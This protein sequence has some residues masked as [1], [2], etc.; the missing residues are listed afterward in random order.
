MLTSWIMISCFCCL[1]QLKVTSRDLIDGGSVCPV[2][3]SGKRICKCCC[4]QKKEEKETVFFYLD[5]EK[6]KEVKK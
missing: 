4:R 1:M 5:G 2:S 3:T 6:W